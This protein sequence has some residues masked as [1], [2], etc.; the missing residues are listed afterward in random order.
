MAEHNPRARY[1]V[2]I[3]NPPIPPSL[4]ADDECCP[5]CDEM[6]ALL[7]LDPDVEVLT[8]DPCPVHGGSR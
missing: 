5:A 7:H 8:G 6:R 2:V 3:T 4:L 1:C